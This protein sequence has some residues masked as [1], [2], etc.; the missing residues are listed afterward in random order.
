MNCIVNGPS[1]F[2]LSMSLFSTARA[3]V[4][5][6]IH[7]EG[8]SGNCKVAATISSVEREDGGGE[9]WNLTMYVTDVKNTAA[10]D[11][12]RATLLRTRIIGNRRLTAYY[13]TDRREGI[14]VG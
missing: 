3:L 11:A 5:F 12:N 4:E 13:R 1:K 14:V 8:F 10:A 7:P 6:E 2:D 9:S